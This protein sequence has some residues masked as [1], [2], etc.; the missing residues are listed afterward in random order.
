MLRQGII[1]HLLT[2]GVL[3]QQREIV[4]LT[5]EQQ[6]Q[7]NAPYLRVEHPAPDAAG[8]ESTNGVAAGQQ[9]Q[10]QP[11]PEAA[12]HRG[13]R[14]RA[15]RRSHIRRRLPGPPEEEDKQPSCEEQ[16]QPLRR[17]ALPER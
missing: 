1:K 11:Q 16:R 2:V 15:F 12:A 4:Q 9:T 6:E 14:Q 13:S 3:F 10:R 8:D 17:A 7:G 5:A